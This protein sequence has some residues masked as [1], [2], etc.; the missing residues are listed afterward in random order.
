MLTSFLLKEKKDHFAQLNYRV[1]K[2]NNEES[3]AILSYLKEMSRV[4]HYNSIAWFEHNFMQ[5]LQNNF[6][7]PNTVWEFAEFQ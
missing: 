7:Y 5:L 3:W 6:D 2:K 4:Q 1:F